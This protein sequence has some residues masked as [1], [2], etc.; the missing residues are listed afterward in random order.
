MKKSVSSLIILVLISLL[1]FHSCKKSV[2]CEDLDCQ[3]GGSP[4]NLN[5]CSCNCPAN[6]TG[7]HCETYV[8]PITHNIWN[9]EITA[10]SG[11]VEVGGYNFTFNT[12]LGR[13][14]ITGYGGKELLKNLSPDPDEAYTF[15]YGYIV[16]TYGVSACQS[17]FSEGLWDEIITEFKFQP[18]PSVGT[19][20]T[21]YIG[22]RTLTPQ[23]KYT[24]GWMKFT[25]THDKLT[26]HESAMRSIAEMS[27]LAG[28]TE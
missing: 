14:I 6:Y 5:G 1:P 25:L 17:C 11:T 13:I 24:Y 7:E 12:S 28:Q 21:A 27:I 2:P 23:N 3:N 18:I 4:I 10:A 16:D 26:I 15:P 22:I 20:E 8:Q 9:E 19:T